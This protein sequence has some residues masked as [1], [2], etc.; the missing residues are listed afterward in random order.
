VETAIAAG[1]T[2]T[3]TA[4]GAGARSQEEEV[5]LVL[6]FGKESTS[7]AIQCVCSA[8]AFRSED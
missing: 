3:E 5:G 6:L 1:D 8:R 2:T 7:L 4:E